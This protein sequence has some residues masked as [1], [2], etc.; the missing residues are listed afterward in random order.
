MK[1]IDKDKW[2]QLTHLISVSHSI[3]LIT[4]IN[5]D[6]DGLGSEIAFYYYL[7]YL[8]KKC[9]IINPTPLPYNYK[10]IDPDK[11]VE[12]YSKSM[13]TWLSQVDL[14]IIFDI[15]DYK[16]VGMIG[17]EIFQSCN[18][19]S[20]D[21]HPIQDGHPFTLNIVDSNAPATGYLVWK[22]FQHIGYAD[23]HFPVNLANALYASIVTDTGS[24]KYQSTTPDTHFMAAQ[25]LESGVDSYEIQK[26][27][28]EQR[29]ISQINLLAEVIKKIKFSNNGQVAWAIITQQ[30]IKISNGTNED[31]EGFAEF[32]RSIHNVEISFLIIENADGSQRITFR[33]SGKYT[34]NDVAKIFNG[35]GH[36]FA[37]GAKSNDLETSDLEKRI[38][39]TL[40]SKLKGDYSVN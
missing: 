12:M 15:G 6:G 26:N 37:A 14:A 36:K 21:H 19:I 7:K 28:Y 23:S 22:Y 1:G 4:H 34:V 31:T 5:A 13:N 11:M 3:I 10:I 33:S 32:I 27:I 40:S 24:F 30:M 38:V 39:N 20:I 35:G 29:K 16:R 25:L 9:R 8:E 2:D 17:E 18:S